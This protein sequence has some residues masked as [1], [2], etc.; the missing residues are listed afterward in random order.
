[1]SRL[2]LAACAVSGLFASGLSAHTGAPDPT[3]APLTYAAPQFRALAPVGTAGVPRGSIDV[4]REY[5]DERARLLRKYMT[6]E[7]QSGGTLAPEDRAAM[8]ADI[9]ELKARYFGS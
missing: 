2:A 4:A 6:L 1:M 7:Q 3:I 8:R 9:A 5:R